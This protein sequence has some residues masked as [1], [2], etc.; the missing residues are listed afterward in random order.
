MIPEAN[1][2]LAH[3]PLVMNDRNILWSITY[4]A[5]FALIYTRLSVLCVGHFI[6]FPQNYEKCPEYLMHASDMASNA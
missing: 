1:T 3:Y 2:L 5:L 4:S 6:L